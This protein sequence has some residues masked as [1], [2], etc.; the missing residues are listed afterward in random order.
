MTDGQEFVFVLGMHRSGTSCLAGALERCGLYLGNVR[1]TGRF[2]KKGYYEQRSVARL[3][4]DIL[5]SHGAS[6][7]EPPQTCEP[8]F[9]QRQQVKEVA[10]R[11][12][13]RRP[14]G[15]KDPRLLLLLGT[16]QELAPDPQA[17]VATFRHPHAVARSLGHRNGMAEEDAIDLW[18]HYNGLLVEAHQRTPFPIVEFDLTHAETYCD[19][20][21]AI[22]NHLGLSPNPFQVR[23]FVDSNLAHDTSDRPI[24]DRCQGTIDYLRRHRFDPQI[25]GDKVHG[26]GGPSARL[27]GAVREARFVTTRMAPER[28]GRASRSA[29][30][31]I[32][33]R[34]RLNRRPAEEYR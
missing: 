22:A 9:E 7:F 16:W 21:V 15:V 19:T 1:R 31:R 28:F 5:E 26:G 18:L 2:N 32:T 24:P 14:C 8:S 13:A 27:R 6:W 23:R 17:I 30:A 3:H 10:R 4:D 33:R 25:G 11:L 20:L 29:A 12:S 34:V